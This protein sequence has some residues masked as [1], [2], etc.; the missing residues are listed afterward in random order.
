MVEALAAR[1]AVV[2]AKE[3]CLQ[4]VEVEGDSL[5]VI[6]ALVAAKSSRTMFGNVIA[7]I[8]C[9]VSNINCSFSHVKREGNKL[10]HAFARRVVASADFDMWLEDLPRDLKD[11][12]QL[13]L[14]KLKFLTSFSKTK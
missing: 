3:L 6:Q 12:F 8:H 2:F 7:D 11:V 14:L 1:R 9:L 10:A 5:C 13:Y 4:S